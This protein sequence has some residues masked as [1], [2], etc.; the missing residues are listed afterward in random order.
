MDANW[1]KL[2]AFYG[3]GDWIRTHDPNLGKVRGAVSKVLMCIIFPF[4]SG[5]IAHALP[6]LTLILPLPECDA[7]H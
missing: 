1:L 6:K 3:A 5:A 7:P 2:L 4:A